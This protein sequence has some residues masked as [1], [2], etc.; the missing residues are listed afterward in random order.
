[1]VLT[2]EQ[3]KINH[4]IA[5][6]KY[7]DANKEKNKQNRQTKKQD[8][9]EY[10]KQYRKDNIETIIIKEKIKHHTKEYIIKQWKRQGII[11]DD[12]DGLYDY[13]IKETNCM[14][15]D[16]IYNTNIVNDKRCLDHDHDLL[17]EPNVR[18]ICCAYCNLHIIVK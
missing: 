10:D 12:W 8:K 15:C 14:I 1:M 17:D 9:K 18:Y 13:F 2:E 11:D 4:N 6:K 5:N 16:K 3:R 7:N